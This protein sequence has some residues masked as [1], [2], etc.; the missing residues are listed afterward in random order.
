MRISNVLPAGLLGL[1]LSISASANPLT[2]VVVDYEAGPLRVFRNDGRFGTGGTWYDA[3]QTNQQRN[4]FLNHRPSVELTF[5]ERH[6]A[7][8]MYAPVRFTTRLE[9]TEALTFRGTA[10]DAGSV[11]EH[12]YQFDGYRGSYLFR[13]VKTDRFRFDVGASLQIRNARV[14]FTQLG[15]TAQHAIDSDIGFVPAIKLRARYDTTFGVYTMFEIDGLSTF[16]LVGN[17]SGGL[18][19]TS[20]TLGLPLTPSADAFFRLRFYGG[21]ANV[22]DRELANWAWFGVASFGLRADLTDLLA[23][24]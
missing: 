18:V 16:G 7:V 12:R 10:F 13:A 6:T 4:L 23:R 22:P 5:G 20:L 11:L 2:R 14:E 15:G 9:P 3:E 24:K 8:L 17:T 19:D 1:L 21:G